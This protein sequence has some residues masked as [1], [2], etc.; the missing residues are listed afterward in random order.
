VRF[1]IKKQRPYELQKELSEQ[2]ISVSREINKTPFSRKREKRPKP[3]G[4]ALRG[5]KGRG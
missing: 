4:A 3:E 5:K 2:E 1:I